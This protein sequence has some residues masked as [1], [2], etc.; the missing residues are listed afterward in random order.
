MIIDGHANACG[1]YNDL[2]SIIT[3][4]DKNKIDKVI[5]SAGEPDSKKDYNYPLMSN[6]F[7]SDKLVYLF[8]KIITF[9]TKVNK[10]SNQIDKQ[11]KYVHTLAKNSNGRILNTYWVNPLDNDCMEKLN[12]SYLSYDFKI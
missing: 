10:L 2:E 3:Y 12:K 9:I 7:K 1:I 11:N 4:L 8:N 6:I 5:L